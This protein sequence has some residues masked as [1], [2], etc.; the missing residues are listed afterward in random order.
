LTETKEES[1][2]KGNK[3]WPVL[4]IIFPFFYLDAGRDTIR[5]SGSFVKKLK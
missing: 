3:K 2:L 4:K 1:I 5:K